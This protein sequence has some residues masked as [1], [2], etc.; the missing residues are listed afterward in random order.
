MTYPPVPYMERTRLYYQAQGFPRPYI[1]AEFS[2]V[3]FS[4]PVKPLS[5]STIALMT[6]A[7]LYDRNATDPRAVTSGLTA[8]PPERLYANDLSWDKEATHLDD[9]NSYFPID[10][11]A[12]LAA[13][14][15]IG[16]LAERF[17]CLPT[18][19]SQRETLE[20]DAPDVL[21]LCQEDGVDVALLVPL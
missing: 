20:E 8:E 17:H 19:Y 10:H 9:R 15:R 5:S 4:L 2:D 7:S 21:R 18:S 14:N 11:L 1:W 3:P 6:T 16:R 12:D 13:G